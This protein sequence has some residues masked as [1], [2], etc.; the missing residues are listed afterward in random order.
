MIAGNGRS[1]MDCVDLVSA[2]PGD[3]S[4]GIGRRFIRNSCPGPAEITWCYADGDN[5]CARGS[6]NMWTLGAGRAWPI[7][8]ER[9]IRWAACHGANTV[10][11]EKGTAGL[12]FICT[13]PKK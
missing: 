3:N 9:E 10:A 7:N 8:P 11:F 13:A 12:R 6:G 4:L 2:K 1:A 5:A